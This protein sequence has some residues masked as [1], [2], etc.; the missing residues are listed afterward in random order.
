MPPNPDPFAH[1]VTVPVTPTAHTMAAPGAPSVVEL[2]PALVRGAVAV[3]VLAV[4]AW[5]TGALPTASHP[6]LALG[7]GAALAATGLAV[8]LHSRIL[9]RR[10]AA[11]MANDPRLIAGRLQGLLAV[12]L[13]LKLFTVT[14]GVLWLRAVGMKFEAVATFAV[15]FAAASLICQVTAAGSL[16]RSTA[17]RGCVAG[18]KAGPTAGEPT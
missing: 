1:A 10:F 16:V 17:R 13:L 12:G 18:D 8:V 4:G 5:A 11:S 2:L 3:G 14:V 6:F 9:D 15:A 7:A